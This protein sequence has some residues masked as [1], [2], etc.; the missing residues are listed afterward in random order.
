MENPNPCHCNLV[1]KNGCAFTHTGQPCGWPDLHGLCPDCGKEGSACTFFDD[2]DRGANACSNFT[3]CVVLC[4]RGAYDGSRRILVTQLKKRIAILSGGENSAEALAFA[5]GHVGT[6]REAVKLDHSIWLPVELMTKDTSFFWNRTTT[7]WKF[8]LERSAG[9]EEVTMTGLLGFLGLTQVEADATS[10]DTGSDALTAALAEIAELKKMVQEL[11]R[12]QTVGTAEQL[13][14]ALQ[15]A[16]HESPGSD[17]PSQVFN[18]ASN[19]AVTVNAPANGTVTLQPP[20]APNTVGDVELVKALS[21]AGLTSAQIMQV[22]Q[23]RVPAVHAREHRNEW[24]Q[25]AEGTSPLCCYTGMQGVTRQAATPKTFR[26]ETFDT[27]S[28]SKITIKLTVWPPADPGSIPPHLVRDLANEW[29]RALTELNVR[30]LHI[31]PPSDR[32][33]VPSVPI[34]VD[35]FLDHIYVSLRAYDFVAVIRAWEATHLYVID[36]Y[37]TKRSQP[38]WDS[39]WMMPVF[40][41]QLQSGARAVGAGSTKTE[42]GE[43]CINWNFQHGQKCKLEPSPDCR[44]LHQCIRCNGPHPFAKCTSRE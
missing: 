2:S 18:L 9:A 3:R 34:N 40:Q 7:P 17:N 22:L 14:A 25:A 44:K 26:V 33:L 31:T 10:K 19:A 39:V 37:L 11:A 24:L 32:G 12:A 1:T 36:E 38:I 21:S 8:S 30:L 20:G 4:L 28:A 6:Y 42:N 29:K 35:R 43:Y 23:S 16:R 41:V 13:G 15:F 5:E 27:T